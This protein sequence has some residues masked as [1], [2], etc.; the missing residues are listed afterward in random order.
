MVKK[1]S[2][3]VRKSKDSVKSVHVEKQPKVSSSA[4]SIA[5]EVS[6]KSVQTNETAFVPCESCAK[7]QTNLKQNADQ[8]INI[9]HY[10][11]IQSQVGKYRASL[12][13]NQLV[14]GWLSGSDLEKWLLEQDKDL[15]K[16]SKQI[17]FLTKNNELL[18][19]KLSE[20]EEIIKKSNQTEKEIKKEL[21]E[22][23]DTREI[24]VKQY[25]KKINDSKTE[26]H[27]K[28]NS[29]ENEI[30]NL[31]QT[32]SNLEEKNQNLNN[33][34]DNNEKIVVEL[35][36]LCFLLFKLNNLIQKG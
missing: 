29:L 12:M 1:N 21:K 5:D 18:K 28:I 24:I 15:S 10:Q 16:I 23:K 8:I 6:N 13:A 20:N 33:L 34:Y 36:K 32:V 9:C 35:S 7:V 11:N 14:G 4:R 17:D 25:E 2:Q 19:S 27:K 3:D 22:E 26:M 31:K 30:K